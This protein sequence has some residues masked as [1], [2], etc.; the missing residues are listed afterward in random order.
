MSIGSEAF[1][2]LPTSSYGPEQLMGYLAGVVAQGHTVYRDPDHQNIFY[3]PISETHRIRI[4]VAVEHSQVQLQYLT[5][6]QSWLDVS[7]LSDLERAVVTLSAR[8]GVI[9]P[10]RP[11]AGRLDVKTPA[12]NY[13]TI[14]GLIGSRRVIAVFDP[15]LDNKTLV[16]LKIILSFGDGRF[17][18]GIRLLGGAE[19]SQGASATFTAEGVAAWLKQQGLVGEARV[20]PPK[21]EHRRFLLLDDG[22]VLITGHSLNSPHKNEA[23]SVGAGDD[24]RAF[25][26]AAWVSASPLVTK[27]TP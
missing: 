10:S 27:A 8:A 3:I 6:I 23:V 21:S 15:Y 22:Q 24:D 7:S 1:P 11:A 5:N 26:D 25:F 14:S 12:E 20:L 13:R 2:P 18:D 17:A 9:W 19:K 4:S 16:E